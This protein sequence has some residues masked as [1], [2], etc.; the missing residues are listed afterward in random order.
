MQATRRW[1]S[2]E[3]KLRR[4]ERHHHQERKIWDQE[5]SE[6]KAQIAALGKKE[7]KLEK[8]EKKRSMINHY[9]NAVTDM[10]R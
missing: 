4:L 9:L 3:K 6:L 8:W 10:E 2:A 7:A 5:Q 1:K